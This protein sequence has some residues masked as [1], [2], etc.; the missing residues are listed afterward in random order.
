[1]TDVTVQYE[2]KFSDGN[3][4]AAC[5]PGRLRVALGLCGA[6]Y[7]ARWAAEHTEPFE[8]TCGHCGHSF[9]LSVIRLTSGGTLEFCSRSCANKARAVSVAERIARKS[10][11]SGG[12]DA[13]WPWN[14]AR[15][16]D[17]YG[18]IQVKGNVRRV[19]RL[20]LGDLDGDLQACHRC[21]NPPCC[22]PAHLFVGS[23]AENHA[24][25]VQKG[26]WRGRGPRRAGR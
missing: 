21:D 25:M 3:Y 22:N 20:L 23:N 8:R 26:R 14:G 12:D 6:C 2:R 5:H 9:R 24:D 4:E 10:D 18:L 19:S 11:R 16:K 1:M 17:G 13:C 7:Q 15:D